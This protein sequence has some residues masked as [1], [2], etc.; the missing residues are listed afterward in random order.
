M[1]IVEGPDGAGK[2]TLVAL[3]RREYGLTP[4]PRF[5]TSTD[6]ITNPDGLLA[7]VAEDLQQL[8]ADFPEKP[9]LYDRHPIISEYVYSPA[10]GRPLAAGFA[11]PNT[12]NI[13]NLVAG[14]SCVIW[15]WPSF[16]TVW[17]NV[18]DEQ[19][20]TQMP[21][22][23]DNIASIYQGYAAQR[24]MWPGE[25]FAHYDYTSPDS[26]TPTCTVIEAFLET[27]TYDY[28]TLQQEKKAGTN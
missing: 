13:R 27:W 12:R 6:G 15:C 9:P 3:L 10:M 28:N 21:G 17:A 16:S 23:V 8:R 1:I 22:V 11:T 24:V 26:L 2:T 25:F 19:G 18:N 5:C 7:Q 14:S 4:H 20:D